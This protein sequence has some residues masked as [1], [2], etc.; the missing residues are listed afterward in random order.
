MVDEALF[1]ASRPPA[2]LLD[3]ARLSE[4]REYMLMFLDQRVYSTVDRETHME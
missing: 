3:L 1:V 4:R 2:G